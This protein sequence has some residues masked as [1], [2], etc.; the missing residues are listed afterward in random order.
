LLLVLALVFRDFV[1]LSSRFQPVWR[2]HDRNESGEARV[3]GP[4][5]FSF[6][7]ILRV[8]DSGA[9]EQMTAT[10]GAALSISAG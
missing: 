8:V 3:N 6:R 10:P 9:A 7:A 4:E 2:S 1:F 5:S